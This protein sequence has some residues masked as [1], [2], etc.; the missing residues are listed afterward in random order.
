MIP[1]SVNHY[2][3]AVVSL[4][5]MGPFGQI[6]TIEAV[7]DTG[8]DG[9]LSLPPDMIAH[10]GLHGKGDGTAQ[11]A[12]GSLI[13]YLIFEASILWD[14]MPRTVDVD[15]GDS[16]PLLGMGLLEGYE[17]TIQARPGGGVRITAL[18]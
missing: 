10:L 9:K 12:D 2:L 18:E 8:F 7:I 6:L 11:L 5:V 4:A 14:G 16:Q 15:A 13:E 1:G 3:E 17:L